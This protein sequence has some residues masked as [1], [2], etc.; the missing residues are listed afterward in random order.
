MRVQKFREGW[1]AID[2]CTNQLEFSYALVISRR[3]QRSWLTGIH[4]DPGNIVT[5]PGQSAVIEAGAVQLENTA[6][7]NGNRIHDAASDPD[8]RILGGA[9]FT[10]QVNACRIRIEALATNMSERRADCHRE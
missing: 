10:G 9:A 1:P 6:Q 5:L 3:C 8:E 2:G 7:S 4:H